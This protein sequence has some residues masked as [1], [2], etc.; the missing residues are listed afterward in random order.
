MMRHFSSSKDFISL[1][2]SS[3]YQ[4]T[5][6]TESQAQIALQSKLCQV[7]RKRKCYNVYLH[8]PWL[9]SWCPRNSYLGFYQLPWGHNIWSTR[10]WPTSIS[11]SFF[12]EM[13]MS[14][15]K[16]IQELT[17]NS[18]RVGYK[19]LST[20]LLFHFSKE[21]DQQRFTLAWIFLTLFF[22]KICTNRR[23]LTSLSFIQVFFLGRSV[24]SPI[25]FNFV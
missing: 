14:R 19:K 18:Y 7:G 25:C 4:L 6:M 17:K 21:F 15:Q 11:L 8:L 23:H 22:M 16:V 3:L 24:L 9:V 12:C 20:Y 13:R 2:S 10:I 1:Q 5:T